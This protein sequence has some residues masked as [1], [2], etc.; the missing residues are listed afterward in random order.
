MWV[1]VFH[2]RVTLWVGFIQIRKSP[3]L[4]SPFDRLVAWLSLPVACGGSAVMLFFLIS[5][6]CI[7]VPY[8]ASSRDFGFRQ[9]ALRRSLR[10]IPPYLFA[11]TL[12]W[13]LEWV[14]FGMGGQ[15]PTGT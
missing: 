4:Y 11:V 2:S 6:F 9:Y 14:V 5:G 8:A 12:T 13:L 15:A 1:I 3:E 7:H 10:I